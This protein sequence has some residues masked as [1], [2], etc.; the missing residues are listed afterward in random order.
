MPRDALAPQRGGHPVPLFGHRI[1][2]HAPRRGGQRADDHA[3]G[4]ELGLHPLDPYGRVLGRQLHRGGDLRTGQFAGRFQPPQG[5]QR[6]VAFVEPAGGFGDL[7]ALSGQAEADDGQ[8]DE[9][10]A[11]VGDVVGVV[12]A[13]GDGGGLVLPPVR[14]YLVHRDGHQPGPEAARV[15]EVA[16]AAEGPEHRLLRHVVH[17]RVAVQRASH[18]VV[19]QGHGR[20]DELVPG[21]P[22]PR[23]RGRNHRR[24][25]FAAHAL[26]TLFRLGLVPSHTQEMLRGRSR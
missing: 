8:P 26:S 22:V 17:V 16:E 13:T 20:G 5:Q 2:Q 25:E 18:D 11:G 15:T 14:P 21:L 9:V 3:G 23:L 19:H 12:Q 6:A 7:P 10:G 1:Q 4:F 24:I